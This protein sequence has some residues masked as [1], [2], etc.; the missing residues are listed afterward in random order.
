MK[1]KTVKLENKEIEVTRLPLRRYSE[2]L[3]ALEELP[4][5]ITGLDKMSNDELFKALPALIS[6]CFPDFVRIFTIATDLTADEI[7]ELSLLEAT[8]LAIA[9][10][11]VND[12]RE[13]FELLKKAMARPNQTIQAVEA[14]QKEATPVTG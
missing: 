10:Y 12:Y 4:K 5:N 8:H 2:L 9:V 1:T 3:A 7:D 13:I 6:K 14:P 11:E